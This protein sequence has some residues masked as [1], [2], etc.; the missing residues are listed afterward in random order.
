[1]GAFDLSNVAL[2]VF[3]A[4]ICLM[5][6]AY[7]LAS[8][9]K[10]DAV[11]RYFVGICFANVLMSL[12]DITSWLPVPP[13][14]GF[15]YGIVVAGSFVYYA[16]VV[17]IYLFFTGYITSYLARYISLSRAAVRC[18]LCAVIV[19]FILYLGCC[20]ASLGNG[21]LFSVSFENGYARG[22]LFWVAQAVPLALHALNTAIILHALPHL[23]VRERV[24]FASYI[25]VPAAADVLQ[26]A[27]FGIALLNPAI[28]IALLAIFMNIQSERKALLAQRDRELVEARADVMLSQI[29][30]HFLYNTLAAIRE[31]C[32]I[33]P[34]EAADVVTDFSVYLRANMASLSSRAPIPFERELE[35]VRTY[36]ALEQRRFGDRLRTVFDVGTVDFS[37]PPL[38]LQVLV[39]NAVRHGVTQL[40]EGGC[41][42]VLVREDGEGVLI[43]VV[44]DGVGFDPAVLHGEDC[45]HVGLANVRTRVE[46]LCGG[47][48][49]VESSPGRGTKATIRLP[50]R[51][52]ASGF[53]MGEGKG[54]KAWRS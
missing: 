54:R 14:G 12:A 51:C 43:E 3:S 47:S 8:G 2:D 30:P 19:V 26:T 39:E 6:G 53:D 49:D 16:S 52:S 40:E 27:S 46:S 25:L 45:S 9:E 13:L 29:Q 10:E 24:G 33:R 34:V 50:K 31:L 38:S 28:A 42:S 44:D 7:V 21:M 18:L 41:V 4:V 15:Q 48:L 32:L 36:L 22:P 1:M 20:I 5:M 37:L 11:G 23:S 17:P 35:H